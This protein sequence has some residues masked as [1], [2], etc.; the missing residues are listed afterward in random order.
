MDFSSPADQPI[1]K[2]F[3]NILEND[4]KG[5]FMVENSGKCFTRCVIKINETPLNE[6]EIGC[7][8]DCY[9]KSFYSSTLG[10]N[11]TLN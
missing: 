3:D 1:A 11:L 5:N 8:K 6:N 10:Q 4:N 2:S 7:L 9:V